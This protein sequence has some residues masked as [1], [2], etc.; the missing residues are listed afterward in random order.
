M[1]GSE[2]VISIQ[3]LLGLIN[4]FLYSNILIALLVATGVYLQFELNLF[5]LEC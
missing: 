5:N 4:E 2:C 3:E 1:K